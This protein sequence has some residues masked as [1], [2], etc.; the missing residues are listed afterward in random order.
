MRPAC[1]SCNCSK[2]PKRVE[3]IY[4]QRLLGGSC[5]TYFQ[6]Y[7][8]RLRRY[9]PHEERAA[10][11]LLKEIAL[12]QPNGVPT[13]RL[14]AIYQKVVGESAKADDFVRLRGDLENDFYIRR[15]E[16]QDAWRFASK[17]LCDWWRRYYAF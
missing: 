16:G 5:K 6:H 14:R 10:K 4:Q 9:D 3:E 17:I 15:D 11:E 1:K 2:G 13:A 8:D 7:Y 12:A